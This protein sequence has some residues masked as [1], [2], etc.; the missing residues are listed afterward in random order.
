MVASLTALG[1]TKVDPGMMSYIIDDATG[2]MYE[3]APSQ[4]GTTT[5][6]NNLH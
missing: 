6:G 3:Y 1:S 5:I 4:M 2:N